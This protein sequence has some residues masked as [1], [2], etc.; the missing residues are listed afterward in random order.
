VPVIE[1]TEVIDPSAIVSPDAVIASDVTIGPYALIGPLVTIGAG[2]YVGPFTRIE[3][4]SRIA[5]RNYFHG[6]ASIGGPPEGRKASGEG[7]RLEIGHDN[8]FREFVTVHRGTPD[9]GGLTSIGS[10]NYFMAHSHVAHDCRLGSNTTIG[11][12]VALGGHVEIGDFVTV[13]GCSCV[14]QFCRVG[15]HAFIGGGS[16]ITQDA[17]PYAKTVSAR[18]TKTYGINHVGLEQKGFAKD[19]IQGLKR[20]YRLLVRSKPPLEDTLT[21]IETDLSGYPEARYLVEF[22]RGSQRGVIR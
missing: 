21:R 7:A 8:V 16:V 17:L 4:P 11:H 12:S 2:C 6:H 20:A 14:H 13:G 22:I 9:G 10:Y 19:T 15:H 18:N 1:V 5:E 3:G